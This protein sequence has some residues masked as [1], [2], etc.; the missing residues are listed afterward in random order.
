MCTLSITIRTNSSVSTGTQVTAL[1]AASECS[2]AEYSS[3]NRAVST[4]STVS[5]AVNALLPVP[6]R[7][8][9]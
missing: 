4:V 1:L 8:A 6:E 9:A 7:T 2:A 5:T 3:V